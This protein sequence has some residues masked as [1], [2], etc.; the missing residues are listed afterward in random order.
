M[1]D[2]STREEIARTNDQ[3]RAGLPTVPPP[4]RLFLTASVADVAGSRL[5]ELFEKIK[6]FKDFTPDNDPYGEHD[7]GFV[8][9]DDEDYYWKFDYLDQDLESYKPDG[10]RF[11]TIMRAGEY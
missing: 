5:N 1:S 2:I 10:I 3:I 6:Q 7:A 4:H 11:L 9:L 8:E